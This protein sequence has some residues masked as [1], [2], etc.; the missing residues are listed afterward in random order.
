MRTALVAGA[1]FAAIA[2][3]PAV[4][5]AQSAEE[6]AVYCSITDLNLRKGPGN[7][8]A[9]FTTVPPGAELRRAPGEVTNEYI[10]VTYNG[11]TGWV[12][13]LGLALPIS[14]VESAPVAEP[15]ELDLYQQDTRVTLTPLMLRTAP[16]L[17]AEPI[18]GMP[19]GALVTLTREGYENGYVTVDYGGARGWAFADLLARMDEVS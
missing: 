2:A 15:S 19:E 12:L 9:I 11:I 13:E 10:P 7:T 6:P 14:E 1:L 18:T 8:D 5:L 16:D 3:T 17:G 4:G